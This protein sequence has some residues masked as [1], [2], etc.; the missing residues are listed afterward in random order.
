[1]E[2]SSYHSISELNS[3]LIHRVLHKSNS[4]SVS[5]IRQAFRNLRYAE[6]RSTNYTWSSNRTYSKR[7]HGSKV[8]TRQHSLLMTRMIAWHNTKKKIFNDVMIVVQ[9][10]TNRM[11]T[12]IVHSYERFTISLKLIGKHHFIVFQAF[13]LVSNSIS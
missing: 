12:K 6:F 8:R 13:F 7:H 1:M 3:L 11:F 2:Y 4:D 5:K 9:S 10:H